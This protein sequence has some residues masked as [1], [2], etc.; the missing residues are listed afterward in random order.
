MDLEGYTFDCSDYKQSNKYV[1][2][3]KRIAEYV[4]PEYKLGGE[5]RS[6]LE[7]KE[8]VTIPHPVTP[9]ADPMLCL[10]Q[11]YSIKKLIYI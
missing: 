6:T 3:I 10:N 2:T 1:S 5:N 11:E 8:Q 4:G 7:N 9:A